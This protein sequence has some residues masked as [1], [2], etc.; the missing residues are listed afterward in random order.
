MAHEENSYYTRPHILTIN[1]EK[2][3]TYEERYSVVYF[4]ILIQLGKRVL[5]ISHHI[6]LSVLL[7]R[8]LAGIVAIVSIANSNAVVKMYIVFDI[9]H[10][11]HLRR[12]M[13]S[14]SNKHTPPGRY[15]IV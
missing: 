15:E 8:F 7:S 14:A 13:V 3:K 2:I 4:S 6:T 5:K 1:Y 12:T 10:R 11:D 9:R